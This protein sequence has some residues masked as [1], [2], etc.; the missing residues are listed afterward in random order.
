MKARAALIENPRMRR[1]HQLA[2]IAKAI[3]TIVHC[4]GSEVSSMKMNISA[5]SNKYIMRFLYDQYETGL[6]LVLP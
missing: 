3:P 4:G 2:R 5:E 6:P 1:L